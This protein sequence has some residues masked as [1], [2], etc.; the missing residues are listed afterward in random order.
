MYVCI[1]Q[2]FVSTSKTKQNQNFE[3]SFVKLV[4]QWVLRVLSFLGFSSDSFISQRKLGSTPLSEGEWFLFENFWEQTFEISFSHDVMPKGLPCYE[5]Y[6]G[7]LIILQLMHLYWFY[8]ILK[9]LYKI[10]SGGEELN[11]NREYDDKDK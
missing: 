6:N 1:Y 5:F 2:R 7:L 9:L 11:D 10:I 3:N 8:F 4:K